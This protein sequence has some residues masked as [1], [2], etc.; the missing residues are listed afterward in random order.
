MFAITYKVSVRSEHLG[1]N[2]ARFKWIVVT[3]PSLHYQFKEGKLIRRDH[4]SLNWHRH[5]PGTTIRHLASLK[6]E[7]KE[8]LW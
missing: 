6:T 1:L 2:L 7:S 3:L 8:V 4:I 5:H